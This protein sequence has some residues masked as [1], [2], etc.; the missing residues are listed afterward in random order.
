MQSQ[1]EKSPPAR[2]HPWFY[3]PDVNQEINL[4]R[5]RGL[6]GGGR[7]KPAA[8]R[9]GAGAPSSGCS[10][11]DGRPVDPKSRR[12]WV[13]VGVGR[14]G[15]RGSSLGTLSAPRILDWISDNLGTK[16]ELPREA[17]CSS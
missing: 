7:G 2:S 1:G 5:R 3:R 16:R 15:C 11:D 9:S 8:G 12:G 10:R 6:S 13:A 4:L 14:I 17:L